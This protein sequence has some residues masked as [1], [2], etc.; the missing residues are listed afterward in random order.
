MLET[1]RAF[2]DAVAALAA[3]RGLPYRFL[4]LSDAA[5]D[6]QPIASYG[7][8]QVRFMEAVSRRYD[9]VGVFQKLW[10]APDGFKL[11]CGRAGPS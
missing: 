5:A 8:G 2:L 4:Y 9:P 1:G 7:P 11:K 3:E 6:Q 10:N